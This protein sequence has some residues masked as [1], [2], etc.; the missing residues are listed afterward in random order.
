MISC[1]HLIHSY[2]SSYIYI[3]I[4]I[5][6]FVDALT[7]AEATLLYQ[8]MHMIRTSC[9]KV[10]CKY[11]DDRWK[12]CLCLIM[13]ILLVINQIMIIIDFLFKWS[14]LNWCYAKCEMR[15]KPVNNDTIHDDVIKWKYFQYH[16]PFVRGIHRAPVN[17]PHK[18]Q[19]CGALMFSLICVWKK[20]Q[21]SK[22]SRSWWFET[23]SH[24]L[25]LHCNAIDAF[26]TSEH[27][28]YC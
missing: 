10:I 6:I 15:Y 16:W 5:Y 22:S 23:P 25:W 7:V 19:R 11:C 17:S 9:G 14:W 27:Y 8:T 12:E 13:M 18:G 20:K 24:S 3:Y 28:S 4:Y 21:L 2:I 1:V 26:I